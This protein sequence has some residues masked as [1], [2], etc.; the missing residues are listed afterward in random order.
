MVT[1]HPVFHLHWCSQCF[2]VFCKLLICTG[3]GRAV[4][5]VIWSNAVPLNPSPLFWRC[6]NF[7]FLAKQ[8]NRQKY[9][10]LLFIFS[11]LPPPWSTPPPTDAR[12]IIKHKSKL[13]HIIIKIIFKILAVY[14][15]PLNIWF[16]LLIACWSLPFYPFWAFPPAS[17]HGIF[18]SLAGRPFPHIFLRL[19]SF[20][21][22]RDSSTPF[23][24]HLE[25][26]EH[27]LSF[28]CLHSY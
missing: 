9:L 16:F 25:S 4:R 28:K 11:L 13:Y 14:Y 15:K 20:S 22:L 18:L 8:E 24:S 2:K 6:Y 17:Y 10:Q 5:L 26:L 12:I 21:S 1:T 27:Y 23:H 3:S 19:L 7:C